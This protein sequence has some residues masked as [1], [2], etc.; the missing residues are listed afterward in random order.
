[1]KWC[2]FLAV[3]TNSL[4][5]RSSSSPLHSLALLFYWFF[6][7]DFLNYIVYYNA[8]ALVHNCT[9]LPKRTVVKTK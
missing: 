6:T 2:V 9:I 7:I 5:S 4:M 1:M 8:A 3:R